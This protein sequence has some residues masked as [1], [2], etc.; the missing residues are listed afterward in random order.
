[1]VPRPHACRDPRPAAHGPVDPPEAAAG[2]ADGAAPRAVICDSWRRS[3]AAG[4]DVE[5]PAAPLVFDADARAA[6]PL[7]RHL[8]RV[9]R[10]W[11]CVGAP[12]TDPDTGHVLDC[13]DLSA[14][15]DALHPAAV[16]LVAA[17][18]RLAESRLELRMQARDELLRERYLRHLRGLGGGAAALV[19]GTGRVLAADPEGWRGLRVPAPRDGAHLTLP[20]GRLAVAETLGEVFLLRAAEPGRREDGRPLLTLS[21]LGADPPHALL[22]GAALPLTLRHA[23][24]LALLALHPRGLSADQL[25]AQLYGDEGNPG[26]IRA[27]IHRLRDRLGELLPAKPYRLECEL[28]ADFLTVRRLLADGG[29]DELTQAAR[30]Y[31]GEL[32]PRSES[33]ELRAERDELAVRLRSQLLDRGGPDALWEYAQTSAG[34]D[35]LEILQ[36]LVAILPP[37]EPRRAAAQSRA[38]RVLSEE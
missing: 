18:A 28:D 5:I 9:L 8:E 15:V 31:Q 14:T 38:H 27:E 29:A 35:D 26:T 7:D 20:D 1:M 32:L 2:A 3:R 19:T 17:A 25:S 33:P 10:R 6:H 30:L 16:G 21:L 23:E 11:S 37:G 13:I 36:R 24:I 22:D 4:G 34:Q 12:V